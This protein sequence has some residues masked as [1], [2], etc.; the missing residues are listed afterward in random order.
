LSLTPPENSRGARA[1]KPAVGL[2]KIGGSAAPVE[3]KIKLTGD[4]ASAFADY[5]RAYEQTH[6]D[7]A[8]KDALAAHMLAAFMESDKG[9]ANWRKNNREAAA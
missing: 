5:Q 6:G 8:D 7:Q 9:F 2:S 1:A 4:A 3:L